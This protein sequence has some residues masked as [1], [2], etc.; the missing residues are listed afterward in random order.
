MK[1]KY[2]YH[3]PVAVKTPLSRIAIA[4]I[5]LTL[6]VAG[7]VYINRTNAAPDTASDQGRSAA[8]KKFVERKFSIDKTPKKQ[9]LK[10]IPKD[11]P[12]LGLTYAGLKRG[13]IDVPSTCEGSYAA[14]V[15]IKGE[16]RRYCTPGPDKV[17]SGRKAVPL[18]TSASMTQNPS[19]PL[20]NANPNILGTSVQCYGDGASGRRVQ[21]LYVTTAANDKF[22]TVQP[23]IEQWAAYA[24]QKLNESAAKT[25]GQRYIKWVTDPSCVPDIK[26]VIVTDTDL[27]DAGKTA[28]AVAAQG[29]NRD[30]RKYLMWT[31][32]TQ[33]CGIAF[34][35]VDD[36]A[37]P[38]NNSNNIYGS[39]AR[40][41]RQCWGYTDST[42]L[43]ELTHTFGGVQDTAPNATLYGH[44]T[45]EYDL[46]CYDDGSNMPMRTVCAN[47]VNET[48][49]DCNNDD[50]FHTNPPAGNY[51][52]THWN[53]ANS[54]FMFSANP[55]D[56]TPPTQPTNFS[57]M[58]VKSTNVYLTWDRS[59]DTQS[60]V[61]YK[62]FRDGVQIGTA[63]DTDG[64]Y[65]HV[66]YYDSPLTPLTAYTYYVVAVDDN[67]NQSAPKQIINVTTLAPDTTA[68]TVPGNLHLTSL[69]PTSFAV[70]WDPSTDSDSG[71]A[72][73][74]ID[75]TQ[76]GP[77]TTTYSRSGL[78][79]GTT[80]TLSVKAVDYAGNQ[81]DPA[82][83]SL[84]FTLPLVDE[85]PTVPQNL[86]VTGKTATT[87]TLSWGP[88]TDLN[89]LSGYYVYRDGVFVG[90]TSASVLTFTDKF[91]T[92]GRTYT[93]QVDAIDNIQQHSGKSN[94]VS[95]TLL[96][97]PLTTSP[98]PAFQYVYRFWSPK[99]QHHFYTANAVEASQV[100]TTYP[101]TTWTYE[102]VAYSTPTDC[103]G[104]SPIYRFWSP[105]NQSH[106]YTMSEQEKV[107]IINTYPS[108]VWT[109]EGVAFCSAATQVPGSTPL[110]RFWSNKLQGHFYTKD[111]AEKDYILAHYP[112]D[113]WKLEG[114]AYYVW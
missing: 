27:T 72:Y 44:C 47:T 16:S 19:T 92:T 104:Q 12:K 95:V 43:H 114:I 45:D 83:S 65:P 67:G 105:T 11:N 94:P 62:I 81:T 71:L 58:F 13:G 91:L 106:F 7:A 88:S 55:V 2:K 22:T 112:S 1:T 82:A 5:L 3:S 21:A 73:Y 75:G 18:T 69:S 41:D 70:A 102:K 68:P 23:Q 98:D 90:S 39:Y 53:T 14:E 111:E 86:T 74:W 78:T 25:G 30:D 17:R 85:P 108:T 54:Y 96:A 48:L 63:Y 99:S 34:M 15:A 101:L 80:I 87:V 49:L 24:S 64:Y 59:I 79:A 110:Y 50:Y 97:S 93:Y 31:E 51:L 46:M 10:S 36:T 76:I 56:T 40:V 8:F 103:N 100:I 60:T 84:T 89:A 57:A 61:M 28:S 4:V 66:F 35:H 77:S 38:T 109:Y 20:A 107:I 42:E 29:Y 26:K 113:T 9:P 6:S 33:Y 52:A 32:G 37:D